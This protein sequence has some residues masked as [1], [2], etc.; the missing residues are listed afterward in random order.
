MAKTQTEE[1]PLSNNI[2]VET[3]NVAPLSNRS[4]ISKIFFFDIASLFFNFIELSNISLFL[5]SEV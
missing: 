4:S 1:A 3:F 5:I 2:L